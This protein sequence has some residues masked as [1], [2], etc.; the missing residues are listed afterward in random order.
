MKFTFIKLPRHRQFNYS[1]MYYD[2]KKEIQ[3][4][5]DRRIREEMG[6]AVEQEEGRGYAD[7]IRGAMRSRIK[8]HFE[9]VR[10]E[11]K[12][13]NLRLVIILIVLMVLFYYLLGSAREWYDLLLQ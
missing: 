9:V 7:R 3:K 8:S 5:R 1:P 2:E 12:R 13:S 11:R 6:L 10:K 4:N